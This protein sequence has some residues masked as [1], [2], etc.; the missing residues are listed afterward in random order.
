MSVLNA[1]QGTASSAPKTDA[2]WNWKRCANVLKG[3][4]PEGI[5][6]QIT[7]R[8]LQVLI[9][10][11]IYYRFNSN[12]VSDNTWAEWAVELEKLQEEYPEIAAKAPYAE[13]FRGFEHSSGYNLPLDDP[14]AVKKA[15]YILRLHQK[16]GG[17]Q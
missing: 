1:R 15:G 6:A 2:G 9:H 7:R 8:R 10:S 11:I 4:D 14:W 17:N 12:V 16:F 13:G 3:S 5:L